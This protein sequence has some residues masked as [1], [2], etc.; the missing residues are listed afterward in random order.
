M[1]DMMCDILS[2]IQLKSF[3]GFIVNLKC[4]HI[5]LIVFL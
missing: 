4:F 5:D 3:I 1:C 2:V